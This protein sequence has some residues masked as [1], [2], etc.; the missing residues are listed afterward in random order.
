[1]A[2]TD[3]TRTLDILCQVKMLA[4]EYRSLTGRPLG[5]TGEIAE[6]EAVRILELQLA[7]VRHPGYDAVR[8]VPGGTQRLQIKGRCVLPGARPGQRIGRIDCEKEWD[9]VLLV[10]LDENL[11]AT[12]IYEADRATVV[13]AL[14]APG[15]RSR[16]ERGSLGISKFKSI[17]KAVWHR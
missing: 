11:D 9:A 10:L 13:A 2:D 14:S 15:S 4:K 12:A 16:N 1:M 7:P 6:Y 8:V 17:G 5:C 3:S